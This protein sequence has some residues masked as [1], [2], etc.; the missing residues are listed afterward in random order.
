MTNKYS[1]MHF[2]DQAERNRIW[3]KFMNKEDVH[4]AIERV[5][6]SI[7][8]M[9]KHPP[10]KLNREDMEFMEIPLAEL[11]I[12][13]RKIKNVPE[14]FNLNEDEIKLIYENYDKLKQRIEQIN[15]QRI[16]WN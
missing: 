4:N 2:K 7:A 11:E 6:G 10:H 16:S 12:A 13:L 3:Q 9:S 8:Y 5:K 1:N 14:V 15:I